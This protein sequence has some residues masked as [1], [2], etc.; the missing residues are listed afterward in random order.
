MKLTNTIIALLLLS[1]FGFNAQENYEVRSIT[2]E[3]NSTLAPDEL[4]DQ[5]QHYGTGWFSDVILFED[6]YLFSGEIFELDKSRLINYYQRNG[7]IK[8][9]ISD[10]IF[11]TD[12]EDKLVEIKIVIDEGRPVLIDSLNFEYSKNFLP[13]AKFRIDE[14]VSL[15]KGS[16]F[17]DDLIGNDQNSILNETMKIGY[18]YAEVNYSL[19]LDTTE[20]LV[21]LTWKINSKSLSE[22]GE[23]SIT[24]NERTDS[25]LIKEKISFQSGDKYNIEKLDATQ[26]RIYDLGL[27]YIV[28][29]NAELSEEEAEI[30]PVKIRLEEAPRFTTKFG[31]GYGRDEKFRVSLNHTW[32]GFIAGARQLK[33]YAKHSALEPYHFRLN[34][35]QPDLIWEYTRLSVSPYIFRQ[36]EPGFTLKRFGADIGLERPLFWDIIGSLTYTF[37][38]S[39]LDTNSLSQTDREKFKLDQAY[40]KSS[41]ALGFERNTADP[42]FSPNSGSYSSISLFY[43]G[44]GLGS[45]YRFF[46][47]S[48]DFRR[49][50]SLFDWLTLAVRLNAGSIFSLDDDKFI[51]PEERFYSGGSSSIRGWGRAELG[52]TDTEGKPIGGKSIWENNVELRY[53]IFSIISG[54]AFMDFGNVWES[55]LTYKIEDLRYA[56]GLGLRVET[57]IGPVRLDFAIPVFE[58]AAKVQYFISVGHAF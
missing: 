10:V 24:G 58:G 45:K 38:R 20:Y 22:F 39:S 13:P 36:T 23:I 48:F 28:S 42:L 18:P 51:P 53:P 9:K 31:V 3:G 15:K 4:L 19:N 44:L 35:L 47:P 41:I 56:S 29:V 30:I 33:F 16:R 11:T 52:P 54:V 55:E 25:E 17:R 27:F 1:F 2:F 57:P 46:R 26:R 5:M 37:E 21:D 12:D 49:Y 40:N 6:P 14:I 8:A 32:R 34:Y 7:F 43:S 50:H